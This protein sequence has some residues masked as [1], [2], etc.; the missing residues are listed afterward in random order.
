MSHAETEIMQFQ[1]MVF[2]LPFFWT[3]YC[4]NSHIV[5]DVFVH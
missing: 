1:E 3:H 5:K 2:A 4:V